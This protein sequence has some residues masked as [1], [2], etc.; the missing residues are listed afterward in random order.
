MSTIS[1]QPGGDYGVHT[2]QCGNAS[3]LLAPAVSCWEA[4]RWELTRS[5]LRRNS[6][7]VQRPE[8][9]PCESELLAGASAKTR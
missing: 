7:S 6:T 3:M 8:P 4:G 2:T 1:N 9:S 5:S